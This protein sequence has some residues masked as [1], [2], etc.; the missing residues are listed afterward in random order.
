MP[1]TITAVGNLVKDPEVKTFEKGSLTKLRIACTDSY[2]DGNGGWK[3]SDTNFYDVTVWRSLGEYAAST[4]K[5]GDKVIVQGKMKYREFKRNDGSNGHAY[6]IDAS[7][8]GLYLSKKTANKTNSVTSS[9]P[10]TATTKD[11]NIWD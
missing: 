2:P 8:L 11:G 4:L 3:D 7:D 10:A 6:E 5:K 9:E 1:Q